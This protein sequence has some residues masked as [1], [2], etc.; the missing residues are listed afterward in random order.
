MH[1]SRTRYWKVFGFL[2]YNFGFFFKITSAEV[3]EDGQLAL[4][5]G[6][7]SAYANPKTLAHVKTCLS[8]YRSVMGR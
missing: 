8:S 5:G 1:I 2:V 6:N 7:K 3:G 4:K